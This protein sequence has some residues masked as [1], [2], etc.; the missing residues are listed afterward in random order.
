MADHDNNEDGTYRLPSPDPNLFGD[1]PA[2]PND[3]PADHES[4][5]ARGRMDFQDEHTRPHQPTLAEQRARQQ[6]EAEAAQQEEQRAQAEYAAAQRS[7]TRRRVLIGG[8]V[9]VGAAALIA[10]FYLVSSAQTT[11]ANCVGA[12]NTDQGSVVNDQYCDESYVTSHGGYVRNNIIFLPI[13]G[14]LFRQYQYYYGGSVSNGHVT[15]GSISPPSSGKIRT[16]SGQTVQRGGFGVPEG[17]SGSSG[18]KGSSGGSGGSG[19]EEGSSGH[20]GHSGGS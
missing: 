19:G 16:G 3:E 11:T 17:S 18:G 7:A 13:G 8:G 4:G 2:A 20:S 10:G 6:A 1:Q 15:G 5:R 14:G 9:V 12:D